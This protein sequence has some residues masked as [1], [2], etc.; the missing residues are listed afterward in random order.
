MPSFVRERLSQ[1]TSIQQ[2]S[3]FTA[4]ASGPTSIPYMDIATT[5]NS[6]QIILL[7]QIMAFS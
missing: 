6:K 1:E 2:P 5:V 7:K 3:L 4:E